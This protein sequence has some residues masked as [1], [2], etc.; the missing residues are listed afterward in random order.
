MTAPVLEQIPS[1]EWVETQRQL[2]A[3]PVTTE[4]RL[5]SLA[6]V[7]EAAPI[8]LCAVD[9]DFRYV[10]VNTCFAAMYG[11]PV[12]AFLGRT[13]REVLPGPAAQIEQHYR[14]ALAADSIQE[15]EITLQDPN[16]E[17]GKRREVTYLRTAQPVH[18]QEGRVVGLSVALLDISARKRIEADLQESE[19][20]LRYTVEL[21]PHIPWRA[22]VMGELT[23]MSPRWGEMTGIK[24][25]QASLKYW[26]LGLKVED[27][28]RV[29]GVWM[30]SVRTGVPYDCCYEVKCVSGW[31]WQR[32]R[33]Y[34]RRDASG[35][36]V[37]WYG[38]VE[39]IH[40]HKV[41][42]D[43]LAVKTANLEEATG[44][45][46]RIA[47]QDHLTGLANRRTFDEVLRKEVR[48]S[49]RSGLPLAL[50]MGDVDR[51]KRLNDTLGHAGGDEVLREVAL[52]L[53]GVIRRP[54]DLAA[55][56]GGEE[57]ALVL[58]NTT[59]EGA[60]EM[61]QRA[62]AAV[63]SLEVQEGLQVTISLGVA[64]LVLPPVGTVEEMAAVLVSAADK[65]L[66]E[67]KGTGRDR[68]VV[69]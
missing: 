63:R 57:F 11:L 40:E 9:L 61:A 66:Y 29:L 60:A 43:A 49:F 18:D 8:G 17:P 55:R 36:I 44:Q 14:A 39:D 19:E 23:F 50:V 64:M 12:S 45:L 42:E 37:S 27:R 58:P 6:I 33:A 52:A 51:F 26:A 65:A 48:R 1:S 16:G 2:P 41:S 28:S 54:G 13:L 22:D 68:V 31:R 4:E 47:R 53:D 67:A 59:L 24:V 10:A 3:R 35:T 69:A 38:T 25:E 30:R 46:A 21:T 34:P 5:R 15:R 62:L 7:F 20:N 32:A 56:F